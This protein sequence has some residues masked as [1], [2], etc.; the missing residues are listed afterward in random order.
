V[1]ALVLHDMNVSVGDAGPPKASPARA[2]AVP[3]SGAPSGPGA[4]ATAPTPAVTKDLEDQLNGEVSA[5]P[6]AYQV[7]T[8][9]SV[10]RD[11]VKVGS[12]YALL[13]RFEG[14]GLLRFE[15]F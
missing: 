6:A 2:V 15:T 14:V 10:L 5:S 3:G 11:L 12:C 13:R 1:T 7:S 9:P 8:V 4:P